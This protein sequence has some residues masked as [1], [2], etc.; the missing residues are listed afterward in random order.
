MIK[1]GTKLLVVD[2]SGA[3]L[4]KCIKLMGKQKISVVGN[5]IS[6]TLSNLKN[7]KK[8]KKRIIYL[9]LIVGTSYWVSRVDGSFIKFFSNRLLVFN[10]S[11]KFL[12]S[13]VY[14]GVLKEIRI[15][16]IKDKNYRKLFQKIISYS[17]LII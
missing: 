2:N 8:V 5:L 6:V 7:S 1:I 3:K 17:S 12:G 15:K 4:A 9:G 10:K 11:F 14:G 13:R 16:S